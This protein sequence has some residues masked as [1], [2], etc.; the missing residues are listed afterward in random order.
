MLKVS[1]SHQ[2]ILT[3]IHDWGLFH[4]ITLMIFALGRSVLRSLGGLLCLLFGT[5]MKGL[6]P[7]GHQTKKKPI[8][9]TQ[10]PLSQPRCEAREA[11]GTVSFVACSLFPPTRTTTTRI[12]P[13]TTSRAWKEAYCRRHHEKLSLSQEEER[14]FE[15]VIFEI[16]QRE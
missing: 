6:W 8:G 1:R 15:E 3:K 13:T 4:Q 16:R 9:K 5:Q 10:H 14:V 11:C 12:I 7:Y 2:I